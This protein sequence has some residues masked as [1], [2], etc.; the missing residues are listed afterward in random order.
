MTYISF[1]A[2]K[3]VCTHTHTFKYIY[4]YIWQTGKKEAQKAKLAKPLKQEVAHFVC[5][6]EAQA[7][8]GRTHKR[9]PTHTHMHML[10]CA[11]HA[12]RE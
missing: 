1:L 8:K 10:M 9:T 11:E 3:D 4:M 12:K 2:I 7:A 6:A 5:Q